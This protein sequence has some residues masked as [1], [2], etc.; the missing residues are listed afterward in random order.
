MSM[1]THDITFGTGGFRGV[2]GEDFT[3]EN[4]QRIAQGLADMVASDGVKT[5]VPI[6]FDNRFL[7][8]AFARWMAEVLAAN[9]IC[10]LL[11]DSPVPTPMVMC[12][13]RDEGCA[14]G[15]MITASH[16][17]YMYNGVKL[18]VRDGADADVAVTRRL[19]AFTKN[20]KE[21][22]A[23]S[24]AQLLTSPLVKAFDNRE[25]YL[26]HIEDF[27]DPSIEDNRL[28]LLFDNLFGVAVVGL[29]PLFDR[30]KLKK[31][32]ILHAERDALFGS[33][34]P[35]PTRQMIAPLQ[36]EV[37]RGKFD[38]AMATDS[39]GDR[40]GILDEQGNY[41]N[42]NDIL[43]CLYYYLV[44]YR[45]MKGDAV[46]NIAT[47]VLLDLLAE[48]LGFACHTVDVGFK[49]IS[50][51][52]RETDALIGGE[53]S[54]GLTCRG[55]L[56][57]KDSTFSGALFM[58]MRIKMDKPVSEIVKEVHAFCGY[59]YACVEDEL[60]LPAMPE[61]GAFARL[62]PDFGREVVRFE[63]L[64][65]NY[66]WHFAGGCWGLLRLSGT[67]PVVRVFAEAETPAAAQNI[68]DVL[69]KICSVNE[70]G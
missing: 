64:N 43:A 19:E 48:R 18:F 39:D 1:E 58:E 25:K 32:V 45:G 14:Y 10:C 46:K 68:A 27:L 37:T 70:R 40:L 51:K 4:V 11:Y 15:L 35:N 36:E 47:S 49:N 31:Y 13:V 56:A 41:V 60:R 44:R 69:K 21:V 17:P 5:F 22:R 24:D 63:Q 20:V 61:E 34:L 7:S 33:R 16:N 62:T 53:S 6:G 50:S 23:L 59:T 42:S 54:G 30:Y 12:A 26:S 29:K 66:K 65:N 9:G 55:Y 67:E 28:H 2:I 38:Y 57:G 52:M 3:K 8:D